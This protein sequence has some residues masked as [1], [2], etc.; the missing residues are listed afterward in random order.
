MRFWSGVVRMAAIWVAVTVGPVLAQQSPE[1]VAVL[2]HNL[3][4]PATGHDVAVT[5]F[6]PGGRPGRPAVMVLPGVQGLEPYRR[7]YEGFAETVARAGFDTYLVE[8]DSET[9]KAEVAGLP[10]DDRRARFRERAAGWCSLIAGVVGDVRMDGPVSRPVALVGFSQGGFLAAGTAAMDDRVRALVVFYGGIPGMLRARMTR[11]P[12]LLE[13]HGDADTVVPPADG[14]AL[15]D[16]AK[17]LGQ[18]AEMVVYPGAGHGF[19]GD[20]ALDAE[21]RTVDFLT[22]RL[23]GH[24]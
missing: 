20:T 3:M 22:R 24:P 14:R 7:F 12:P 19:D 13:L 21:K 15:V 1:P 9:E 11:L 18:E 23:T 4:L 17:A 10:A 6:S 5:L 2:R 16:L 8:Y